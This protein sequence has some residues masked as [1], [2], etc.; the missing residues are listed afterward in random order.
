MVVGGIIRLG[1]GGCRGRVRGVVVV[2]VLGEVVG[3]GLGGAVVRAG[4]VGRR[5]R[6]VLVAL[7]SGM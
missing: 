6:L 5:M 7:G 3:L 2:V 1:E 4:R